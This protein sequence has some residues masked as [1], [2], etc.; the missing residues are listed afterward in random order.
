[1]CL[2][3]VPEAFGVGIGEH[4]LPSLAGVGGFV[5]AAEGAFAAGHDDG[6]RGVEGLDAAEVEVVGVGWSG[7]ALPVFAVVGGAEDRAFG[8]AGPC[9]AV[10]NGMNAAEVGGGAGVLDGPLG[11]C[12][13]N[14]S[15]SCAEE[16]GGADEA[17]HAEKCS[18]CS[19]AQPE[20]PGAEAPLFGAGDSAA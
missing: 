9:D 6:G 5:E 7:A 18:G 10:A 4:E 11:L 12:V 14:C 8:S 20:R 17:S 16:H 3:C 1:M 2:N 13:W 19:R 15:S